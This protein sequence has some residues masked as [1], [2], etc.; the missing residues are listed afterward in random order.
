[1]RSLPTG[2]KR[3]ADWDSGLLCVLGALVV[4][5]RRQ[6]RR[7]ASKVIPKLAQSQIFRAYFQHHVKRAQSFCHPQKVNE[8]E[9]V[10]II[11]MVV[12]ASLTHFGGLAAISAIY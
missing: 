3:G 12:P 11:G 7:E 4:Q 9:W 10:G 8:F 2:G 5:S 6:I 1:M